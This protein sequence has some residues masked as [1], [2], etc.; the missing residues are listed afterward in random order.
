[1]EPNF[2]PNGKCLL[3][4]HPALVQSG[5]GSE[6]SYLITS[7]PCGTYKVSRSLAASEG[8]WKKHADKLHL[9]AGLARR[10]S[11]AGKPLS[12]STQHLSEEE[13]IDAL[14][15]G[16]RPP[17]DPLEQIDELLLLVFDR[18][19]RAAALAFFTPESDY[20]LIFSERDYEFEW[21]L[22]KAEDLGF[23]ETEGTP[24]GLAVTLTIPG[25]QRVKE[26]KQNRTKSDQAFVAMAFSNDLEE[27]GRRASNPPSQAWDGDLCGST[28]LST[29][30]RLMTSS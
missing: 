28:A 6:D 27:A 14:I 30:R 2:E 24:A 7:K 25:W 5:P 15:S 19:G 16:V 10:Y 9:I 21:V 23:I 12:L 4:G 18:A 11:D 8:L 29:T 26:L 20:P 13:L 17:A 22:K 1:M 3:T